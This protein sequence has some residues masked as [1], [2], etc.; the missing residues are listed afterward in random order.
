MS[1]GLVIGYGNPLRGDDGLGWYAAQA[2]AGDD[3]NVEIIACHQL[4]PELAEPISRADFVIFIDACSGRTAGHLTCEPIEP[5][6]SADA[7]STHHMTPTALLVWA[8]QLFGRS[9]RAMTLSIVGQSF[10]LGTEL[11]DV[12]RAAMPQLLMY[13]KGICAAAQEDYQHA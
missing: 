13:V 5:V 9:P 2:L 4:T 12:I 8:A 11:S 6:S 3:S 1:K 10:E 7:P